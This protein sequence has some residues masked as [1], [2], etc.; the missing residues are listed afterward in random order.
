MEPKSLYGLDWRRSQIFEIHLEENIL[1]LTSITAP[2]LQKVK[3]TFE[4]KE[5]AYLCQPHTEKQN[6]QEINIHI[7]FSHVL[8]PHD[9]ERRIYGV[10]KFSPDRF[11]ILGNSI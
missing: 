9:P 6:L 2:R 4:R 10:W 11:I 3:R 8:P 1:D 7:L 5:N